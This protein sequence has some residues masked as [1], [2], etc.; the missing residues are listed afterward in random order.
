[1]YSYVCVCFLD[2]CL[3]VSLAFGLIPSVLCFVSRTELTI[4]ATTLTLS[5][6]LKHTAKPF[7]W[8][9]WGLEMGWLLML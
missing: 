1:M 5:A 3:E 4:Y 8:W 7:R 6:T 2:T 9:T